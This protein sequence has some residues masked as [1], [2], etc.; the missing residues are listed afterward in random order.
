MTILSDFSCIEIGNGFL[1]RQTEGATVS[2]C[3]ITAN[4]DGVDEG[5][6]EDEGEASTSPKKT[7]VNM[8]EYKDDEHVGMN[9]ED[10][11]EYDDYG[12]DH[13]LDDVKQDWGKKV[14]YCSS[15][16]IRMLTTSF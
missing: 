2:G 8:K 7:N 5:G 1:P 6:E 12:F 13:E 15:N 4:E 9:D 10:G 14:M 3:R 11:H 16:S